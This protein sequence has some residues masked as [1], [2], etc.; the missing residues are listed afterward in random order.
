MK[1][2]VH[3]IYAGYRNLI[4]H[5]KYRWWV[6]IGTLVYLI[7][8]FDLSPDVVPILGQLDD[9]VL[10]TLLVSEVSQ[11]VLDWFKARKGESET[12]ASEDA[13]VGKAVTVE[14]VPVHE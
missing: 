12:P 4:R 6:I 9:V 5:S 3:A 14:A 1:V 10:L 2:S 13:G 8:P 7:I 11:V